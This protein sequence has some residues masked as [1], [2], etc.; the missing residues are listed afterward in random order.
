MHI[1]VLSKRLIWQSL[2]K[3]STV[4]CIDFGMFCILGQVLYLHFYA[5][6]YKWNLSEL[7]LDKRLDFF[8]SNWA[9]FLGFGTIRSKFSYAKS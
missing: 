4:L 5:F 3:F 7:S 2:L 8:E 9:F 1:I 6:R